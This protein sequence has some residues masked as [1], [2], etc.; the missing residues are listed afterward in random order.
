MAAQQALHARIIRLQAKR[1]ER[2]PAQVNDINVIAQ[3]IAQSRVHGTPGEIIFLAV[4]LAEQVLVEQ[5]DALD[6]RP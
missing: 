3:N 4:S 1:S 5:A 6:S 2:P